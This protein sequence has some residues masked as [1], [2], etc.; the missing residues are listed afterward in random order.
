MSSEPASKQSAMPPPAA[1]I[2]RRFER[3]ARLLGPAAMDALTRAH[4]TIF[5]L[6][7]V[8]SWAAE[9]LVRGGIGRLTLVDFDTVCVTNVNR[10]L[11]ALH[12]TVG[13]YKADVVAE[14]MRLINPDAHIEALREFYCDETAERLLPPTGVDFVVDAVDNVKA[15]LHLLARCLA[16]KI[17]VISSMGAAGRLDP[18]LVRVT[19]LY[20]SHT[21][22]FAKDVR[23]FLRIKHG[24]PA[25]TEPT[26]ILAVWSTERPRD[27][28]EPEEQPLCDATPDHP[29]EGHEPH[30]T[31]R[32]KQVN[33]S[34][35]FV[36]GVFGMV[37]AGEVIRRIA[38]LT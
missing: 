9:A 24:I 38:G 1:A 25:T 2:H 30:S 13:A 14:R 26:G 18:T 36:T 6:G 37:A 23:K 19:D 32:R 22:Q 5:G 15:K 34:A 10:Q 16:S 27:P 12:S 33:G 35:G 28:I 20:E 4:V 3:N 7:G 29:E 8:G 21:D 17:P 31:A 11:P